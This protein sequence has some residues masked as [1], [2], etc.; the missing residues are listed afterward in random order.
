[1]SILLTLFV[2]GPI[3]WVGS[4]N[5]SDVWMGIGGCLIL[6]LGI[7]GQAVFWFVSL[8]AN[9]AAADHM[10]LEGKARKYIPFDSPR[11]TA[12]WARMTE[13]PKWPKVRPK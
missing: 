13:D 11:R 9:S 7:G 2:G 3:F 12:Q 1:V 5:S 4:S 8:R 10:H 6:L